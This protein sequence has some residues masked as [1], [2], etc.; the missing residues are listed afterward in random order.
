MAD[1]VTYKREVK[2][3]GQELGLEGKDLIDYIERAVAEFKE[4]RDRQERREK[5]EREREREEKD[6]Q[7]R[8]EKEEHEREKELRERDDRLRKE[9]EAREDRLRELDLQERREREK[10]ERV[11]KET[12]RLQNLEA[13]KLNPE[14]APQ[15]LK[16]LQDNAKPT[17]SYS[18]ASVASFPFG[19]Y[20]EKE[21]SIDRYLTRFEKAARTFDLP[22]D[23]WC[24][25][26]SL[27]L[28]GRAFD[29]YDKLST[30][31]ETDYNT[32][33]NALLVKFELTA[34]CYRKKFRGARKD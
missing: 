20:Q 19:E 32:L 26:L 16:E 30:E 17:P 13:I 11:A 25:R 14:L 29:V 4:E 31:G 21:E 8:K 33:K 2:V 22:E 1:L 15:L 28:R 5:E 10:A 3:E 12:A 9:A 7:E 6:R 34:N 27:L 23:K 24:D 18:T